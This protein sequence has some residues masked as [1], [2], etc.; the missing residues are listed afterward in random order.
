MAVK[1]TAK[2]G[3]DTY[4]VLIKQYPLSRIHDNKD[5]ARAHAVIDRLLQEQLDAGAQQ[6]LDALA[7]LVEVYEDKHVEIPDASG[8]DV[9]RELMRTGGLSQA[10]L[11]VAVGIAQSTLSD[12]INGKRPFTSD[13]AVALGRFFQVSPA[14]FLPAR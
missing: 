4:F 12:L 2:M 3:L 14:V 13:H 11:A 10:K 6:Y 1:T 7:D 9:L 5:L 8:A